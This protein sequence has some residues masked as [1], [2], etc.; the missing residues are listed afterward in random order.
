MT[1]GS[2]PTRPAPNAGRLWSG[3]LAAA[4]VAA[5]IAVAGIVIARGVFDIPVLAPESDGTWGSASTVWYAVGA[6]LAA[7]LATG[8]MHVLLLTTPQPFRFFGWVIGLMTVIAAVLPFTSNDTL[9]A[10]ITTGVINVVIGV[11]IG[12]LVASVGRAALRAGL[13]RPPPTP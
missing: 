4:L 5:L 13:R 7:L 2:A 8:L 11:A 3:G 6:A 9:S 10:K 1:D 12:S